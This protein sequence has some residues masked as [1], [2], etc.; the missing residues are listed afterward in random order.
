MLPGLS[1]S[2][3]AGHPDNGKQAGIFLKGQC[4]TSWCTALLPVFF[5]VTVL[6]SPWCWGRETNSFAHL[7]SPAL[8]PRTGPSGSSWPH[9]THRQSPQAYL[10]TKNPRASSPGP[11][12]LTGESPSTRMLGPAEV[13]SYFKGK[14]PNPLH[15]PS[16]PN[17]SLS[18]SLRLRWTAGFAGPGLRED[19]DMALM[20][21]GSCSLDILMKRACIFTGV[22]LSA[23]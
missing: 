19:R 6:A 1:P 8:V 15:P 4:P 22:I 18:D 17:P 21:G 20:V 11:H 2:L 23:S 16:S 13:G 9:V 3:Q 7:F 14:D 5:S 10:G 12:R